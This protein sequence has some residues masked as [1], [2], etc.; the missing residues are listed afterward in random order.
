MPYE[1][2]S[3]VIKIETLCCFLKARNRQ[4]LLRAK[5]HGAIYIHLRNNTEKEHESS[6][7]WCSR[8]FSQLLLLHLMS[9]FW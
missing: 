5:I 2:N 7:S 6:E 8:Y 4:K 9:G 3:G 1:E